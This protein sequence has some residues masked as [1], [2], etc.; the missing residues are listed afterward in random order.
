VAVVIIKSEKIH[1][2][3]IQGKERSK[4]H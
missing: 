3:H 4:G 1:T 2:Y